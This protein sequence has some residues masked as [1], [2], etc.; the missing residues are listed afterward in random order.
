MRKVNLLLS[1]LSSAVVFGG[2]MMLDATPANA[3]DMWACTDAQKDYAAGVGG[4]VCG[5]A[6]GTITISCDGANIT[7]HEIDC[8]TN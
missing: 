2:A 1:A 7:V 5:S 6:G 3:S 4:S 8:N